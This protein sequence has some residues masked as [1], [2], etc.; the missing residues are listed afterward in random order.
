MNVWI[1]NMFF[2]KENDNNVNQNNSL[3]LKRELEKW[4]TYCDIL[5]KPNRDLFNQMLFSI[6][7]Y[8]SSID[9]KGENY[10]TGSLFMSLKFEQYKK[11]IFNSNH[12]Y[13]QQQLF[14]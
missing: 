2:S 12:N 9:A 7:K 6:Y 1:R 5:R 4:R 8:S 13:K 14:K 10:S 11:M 3:I